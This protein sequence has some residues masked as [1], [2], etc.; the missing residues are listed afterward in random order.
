MSRSR[1]SRRSHAASTAV[2]PTPSAAPG[3]GSDAIELLGLADRPVAIGFFDAPPEGLP[4]WAGPRVPAGCQFWRHVQAG[5]AFYT[6]PRDHLNCLPGYDL[7]GW[8]LGET[9]ALDLV[10]MRDFFARK[11]YALAD[12]V[13][14]LPRL[15]RPPA[16]VAYG[17]ADLAAFDPSV[18]LLAVTPAQAL[19]VRDAARRAGLCG[20]SVEAVA[21]P[22]CGVLARV[23]TTGR[24]AASFGCA[25]SR[26]FAGLP[27][28]Q[29]YVALPGH[30]WQAFGKAIA[31]VVAAHRALDAYFALRGELFGAACACCR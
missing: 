21:G 17:P 8:P 11:R 26:A 10:R 1:P 13:A 19:L 31:E 2:A 27:P 16:C 18:V 24:C 6:V 9:Q 12:E 14:G 15:E 7:H 23:A 3:P 30:G 4:R 25:G 20:E 28:D 22:A 5:H 29:Q